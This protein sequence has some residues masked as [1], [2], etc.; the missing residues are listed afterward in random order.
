MRFLSRRTR[1]AL[2]LSSF[3]LSGTAPSASAQSLVPPE[4]REARAILQQLV[5]INS[6]TGSLGVQKAARAMAARFI[7]AGYAAADVQLV[8]PTPPMTA[9]IVRL[10]GRQSGKKPI[11]L[12]AHLDVVAAKRADWP[13]VALLCSRESI[14]I[15]RELGDAV[16]EADGLNQQAMSLEAVGNHAAA[17]SAANEARLLIRPEM[18]THFASL[19]AKLALTDAELS[20]PSLSRAPDRAAEAVAYYA[21]QNELSRLP[22]ALAIKANRL[23]AAGNS[24]AARQTLAQGL[25]QVAAL[26]RKSPGSAAIAYADS[27]RPLIDEFLDLAISEDRTEE[28]F[29]ALEG[30]RTIGGDTPLSLPVIQSQLAADAKAPR[31]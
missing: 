20:L 5:S 1:V 3:A 4:R 18:G 23:R 30:T 17:V 22:E 11:L 8:G 28:A 10:R 19:N 2:L 16:G 24:E 31:A 6:T 13:H 12:L 15:A 7:A 27:R 9:L 29:S 26:Q 14:S 25:E 21:S